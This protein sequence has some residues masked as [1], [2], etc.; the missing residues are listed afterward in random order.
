[1][2]NLLPKHSV[3]TS[4]RDPMKQHKSSSLKD[5]NYH[6]E[7]YNLFLSNKKQIGLGTNSNNN[8]FFSN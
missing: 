3:I 7:S 6:N 5:L 1:M 2:C 4:Y 8:F